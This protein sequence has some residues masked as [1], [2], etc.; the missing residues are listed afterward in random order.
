MKDEYDIGRGLL[1][2]VLWVEGEGDMDGDKIVFSAQM[3]TTC[4]VIHKGNPEKQ[5]SVEVLFN[6]DSILKRLD[7]YHAYR[8]IRGRV[9]RGP[10]KGRVVA[11]VFP[12]Y[13]NIPAVGLKTV[14]WSRLS[15]TPHL[16]LPDIA[17]HEVL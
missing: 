3:K 9:K 5:P 12:N 16:F 10:G 7:L 15:N 8:V 6:H 14:D 1:K 13:V 11:R 17:K 4:G 2:P